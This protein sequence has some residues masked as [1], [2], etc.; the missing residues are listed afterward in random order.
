MAEKTPVA[1]LI[2][3]RGSNMAALLAAARDPAFPARVVLVASNRPGAAGLAHAAAEGVPTATIDHRRHPSREAFE[4]A[5]D[6]ALAAAGA[7]IVCLAGFMRVLTGPFTERWRD[8]LLNI[9]PSLLPAFRGLDTHRRALEAGVKIHGCTVHL[10]RPELDDG[11]ILMQAAVP[12]L[13]G[14]DEARLSARVLARE[15]QI[16]PAALAAFLAARAGAP[17]AVRDP[18]ADA[19]LLS[20]VP[21]PPPGPA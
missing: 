5:L 15:H 18:A 11:P 10:V 17:T 7:E 20:P 4:A 2:S 9:H 12:V 3:G 16:Y 21:A 14:D 19:A 6:E 1:I 13:P 8:R